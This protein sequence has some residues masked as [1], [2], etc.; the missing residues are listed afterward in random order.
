[1]AAQLDKTKPLPVLLSLQVLGFREKNNTQLMTSLLV[2][3]PCCVPPTE[4]G[5]TSMSG[6][7]QILGPNPKRG[8]SGCYTIPLCLLSVVMSSWGLEKNAEPAVASHRLQA[9]AE[10]GQD[11]KMHGRKRKARGPHLSATSFSYHTGPSARQHEA[12]ANKTRPLQP[13]L[14]G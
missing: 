10:T 3:R 5:H 12:E 14:A 1:M 4:S 8:S 7:F 9:W 2:A 11:G 13:G 6:A